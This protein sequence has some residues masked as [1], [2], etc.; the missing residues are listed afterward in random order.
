MSETGDAVQFVT[1]Q[2]SRIVDAIDLI[3]AQGDLDAEQIDVLYS[4][5]RSAERLSEEAH[6]V[7]NAFNEEL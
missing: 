7:Y 3:L 6:T 4:L 2:I 1:R 5:Y